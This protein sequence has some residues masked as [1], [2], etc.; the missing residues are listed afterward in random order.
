MLLERKRN[1]RRGAARAP[2][3]YLSSVNWRGIGL[4]LAALALSALALA[5]LLWLLDQPIQRVIV[6]GRLQRV[7]ALDVER[8]VRSRLHGA[9]LVTVDLED[10]SGGLRT[11]PWV[12]S[13]TVQRSWPRALRIEIIEQAAVARW[14]DSGLLN[15]RGQLFM[16][17]AHFVPPE[18]AQLSGP[19]GSEAQATA[20]Y[21]A[22]QGRLTEAGLRLI[23]L[24]LDARGALSL[25]L[26]N[27][28]ELRLGRQ[29][30]DARFE[31]FMT[32]AAKLVSQRAT[33]IAYVDMRY[34]NGFAV[35]WKGGGAHMA[36]RPQ[37]QVGAVE[38]VHI[39]G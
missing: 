20:R 39:D 21:L 10:I 8:I 22:I 14:N 9:G 30:I 34:G 13:A 28:V 23:A 33:D 12:D 27:G 17:E 4:S 26:D 3:R 35:G 15:A 19:V 5:T 37:A 6:S 11:L 2:R 24:T 32:V 29:Q 25:R 16:S 7:S 31:R 18:L 1:N 36:W 38:E